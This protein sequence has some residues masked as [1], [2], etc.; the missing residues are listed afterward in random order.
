[1]FIAMN[2][3][4]VKASE[5]DAFEKVW[6]ERESFLS[7]FS[8]FVEFQL[9]R[10]KPAS[11]PGP[12]QPEEGEASVTFV[13]HSRWL[14]E[15]AF[16]EWVN[17]D[18][19]KQ[20]HSGSS[21]TKGMVLGPP[22]FEGF[23][24]RMQ[25]V[26]G[27]RRDY[28]SMRQDLLVEREF[29]RETPE[30][31][32][33]KEWARQEGFPPIRIGA[34]EGRLLEVLLRA[35]GARRGVEIGTLGGYSA[36]WL[37]RGLSQ[38]GELHSLEL[39]AERAEKVSNKFN[40]L[41]WGSRATVHAGAALETLSGPLKDLEELDF[42]FIDADKSSYGHYAEWAIPRL[43]KGGLLLA[44]NAYIWGAMEYFGRDAEELPKDLY[45]AKLPYSKSQFR[46][47]SHCWQQMA[48]HS[49]LSGLILPTGEGLG[50]AVKI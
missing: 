12:G 21:K 15:E 36:S 37:L 45:G 30:Q 4:Q 11:R 32:E 13:S 16:M 7:E 14:N 44:D 27:E 1:M 38:D 33:L 2:S 42:V 20:A 19:M 46:G 34:F 48:T 5:A 17:S 50:I 25:Q 24:V 23:D 26:A 31:L 28:R 22:K 10:S 29:V 18:R 41:G 8:G 9:L 39:D 3:F 47:M 49:E 43:R 40:D 35:Q 6:R